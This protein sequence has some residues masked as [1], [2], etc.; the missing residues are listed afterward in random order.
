M[1]EAPATEIRWGVEQSASATRNRGDDLVDM[2]VRLLEHADYRQGAEADIT[3][4]QVPEAEEEPAQYEQVGIDEV[5]FVKAM[6]DEDYQRG[7]E[8][9]RS[10]A[11]QISAPEL[12]GYRAWWWYLTSVAA[13]L[14]GEP[15]VERDA[16]QTRFEMRCQLWV[17]QSSPSRSR[18][19]ADSADSHWY[20]A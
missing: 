19:G 9:A 16:L 15:N 5:R 8:L 18:R 3:S 7:L 12:S 6:W 17:V 1:A 4:V 10:I 2:I 11:D 13:F 14:A 20:R